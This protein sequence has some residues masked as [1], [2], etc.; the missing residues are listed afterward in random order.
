MKKEEYEEIVRKAKDHI[1]EGDIIQVVLS[2]RFSCE[3]SGD[4][5]IL[6][7]LLRSLNPSP[8][9]FYLNFREVK[10]I[11]ASP[12]IL[13]RLTDGK[14]VLRPIAGTRPPPPKASPATFAP[15]SRIIRRT[16]PEATRR[17]SASKISRSPTSCGS[18]LLLRGR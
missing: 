10:L 7:R 13:V 2:Q 15:L 18:P 11:G 3:F 16:W 4:D 6:Y 17:S 5:F 14:I 8:Y 1:V 12:E 9:M